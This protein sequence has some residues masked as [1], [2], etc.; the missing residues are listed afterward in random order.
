MLACGLGDSMLRLNAVRLTPMILL[1]K[2]TG[3][4]ENRKIN[5]LLG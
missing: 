1:Y 3:E 4:L 5:V 2:Y